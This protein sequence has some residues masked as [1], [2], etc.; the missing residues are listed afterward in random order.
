[1]VKRVFNIFN[2]EIK[3]LHE[4]AYLLAFF[5]LLSQILALIR[6]RIFAGTF[7]AGQTLD[8]YYSA[9]RI[10]DFIF[11]TVG[12]MVSISVLVPFIIKKLNISKEETQNFIRSIFLF[13]SIL[14]ISTSII[15][16]FL[17][18]FIAPNI[19]KGIGQY[20]ELIK[21]S[22]IL[23]LSPILLGLS[24]MVASIT[25]VGK[26]F[27]VYAL[28]PLFYN[29]GIILGVLFFYP[30][31]GMYGLAYGVILGALMHLLI[32]TPFI[33]ESGLFKIFP[34]KINFNE[35]KEVILISIPRTITLGMTQIS[36]VVLLG[37]AS[38][39][40]E[41]SITIFSFAM[42]LQTVPLAIVGVSYS[43][44]AFPTLAKS[45]SLGNRDEFL[46]HIISGARHIIFWS[47]PISILFVVL[48]AQ[49]VRTIYGAGEFTWASTKLTAATLAIFAVSVVAQSLV[50]LFIRGYYA[51][52]NTVKSLYSS[53]VTGISSV[54]FSLLFIKIYEVSDFFKYFIENLFRVEDL[55]GSKILMLAFGFAFAQLLNCLILWLN[56][57][58]D[59]KG[60]S[61]PLFHTMFNSIS[62]SIIMGF[63]TYIGLNIFDNIFNINTLIGI[64]MQGFLSGILG[65]IFAVLVLKALKSAELKEVWRALHKKFWKTKTVIPDMKEV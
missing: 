51:T 19:F 35:I 33:I 53:V 20:D 7:G 27:L 46:G 29:M 11:V 24:N 30:I 38:L 15:A 42:N 25:Q 21:M 23:L 49:I 22:R 32:Q 9:F 47:I 26:R 37:L 16:F 59:F 1:M 8:I 48:R 52:G 56:F 36:I 54:V 65:I 45:F 58:K 63:V 50:L 39:M 6:D 18:P 43:I 44:A 5:A 17:I 57:E 2:R 34:L 64:F 40:E 55:V 12:S 4:A 3:G 31:W 10:P 41:G 28:C 13:F 14:I 61:V 62:A 60:F